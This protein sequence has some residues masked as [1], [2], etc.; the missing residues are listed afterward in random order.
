MRGVGLRLGEGV[1][2]QVADLDFGNQRIVVRGGK[3]LKDRIPNFT[4]PTTYGSFFVSSHPQTSQQTICS[5][6]E[7]F[8]AHDEYHRFD[9]YKTFSVL[10]PSKSMFYNTTFNAVYDE[11]INIQHSLTTFQR[12][13][14]F[15][16]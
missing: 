4:G 15:A 10:Y 9:S 5:F 2:L 3:G 1:S 16:N 13:M 6:Q 8:K 12:R 14:L 11:T 7:C